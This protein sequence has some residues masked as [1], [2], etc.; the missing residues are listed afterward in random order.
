MRNSYINGNDQGAPYVVVPYMH[1]PSDGQTLHRFFFH[2]P[3]DDYI[4][5]KCIDE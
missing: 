1:E 4:Q 2:F 5:R 3:L